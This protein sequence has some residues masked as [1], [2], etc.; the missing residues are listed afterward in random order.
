MPIMLTRK[1]GPPTPFRNAEYIP[2]YYFIPKSIL[3]RCGAELNA[4][5]RNPQ[6]LFHNRAA[7]EFVESDLFRLLIIDATAFM[8]WPYM[9]F[10]EY[11]EIYSGY[12]P[13]WRFA[14]CPDYWIQ[15]L[16]DEGILASAGELFKGCHS[17]LG[18]VPEWQIDIYLRHIVPN[19]MKKHRM[20]EIIQ[21]AR[22]YPCFEDFD[23]RKSNQKT[24]FIRKWYHTRTRHPMIS[25][26][27]FQEAY[28]DAH[29]GQEYEEPDPSQNVE[30]TVVAQA[31]VDQFKATLSEKDMQ[32]L[33]LRM[34]GDTLEEIAEKLGYKNH[35]GVLKRIRKIGQ[36]YEAYT[37]VDYGFEGGKI[38]G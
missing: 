4:I 28:A 26:E 15:E 31:L 3:S 22:E 16:T 17:A 20:D 18:Y 19:V 6:E 35:S 34:S 25:L 29:G 7:C 1:D 33:E 13:A 12:D 2:F 5:P 14:H 8:V 38:T 37:G 11:M 30:E 21:V 27:E 23:F 9:G 10:G 24:D 32:I 36:A